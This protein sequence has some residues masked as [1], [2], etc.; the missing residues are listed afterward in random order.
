MCQEKTGGKYEKIS[1][2]IYLTDI[3]YGAIYMGIFDRFRKKEK[4]QKGALL[5]AEATLQ[6]KPEGVINTD[7]I[8][9]AEGILQKYKQGKANLEA[10]II[11]NE[12]W[13]KLRHWEELKKKSKPGEPEPVSAWLFNSIANKHADAMD[14]SPAPVVLPREQSDE[15]AAKALT[16][17]LPVVLDQNEYDQ[18]YSDMWW[19]KLKTGTGVTGVFWDSSKQNGLGDI[20]IRTIDLLNLFWEPG[21]KDIQKSPNLFHVE[22]V[23]N[24]LLKQRYPEC[25]EKLSSPT[26]DIGR[27]IYEDSID[28]SDK[29]AVVDWYYKVNVNGRD[30]VHFCK[31]V[32]GTVL[33]ASENDPEY[34]ERGFYDH[35]QY[36][37]VF[38]T[39]FPEEGTPCGF[40]YIDVGKSPQAYIDKLDQCIQ[41]Y[42]VM[43]ANPRFFVRGD[44]G[45]NE[46]EYADWTKAFIHYS[47]N[48]DPSESVMP[49]QIPPLSDI[50]VSVRQLKVEELKET[51]G[52]RDFS[53]GG[54]AAGVTAASAIAALQEAGNKLSRDMLKSSYRAFKKVVSLSIE[55]MRQFY[56]TPRYFRVISDGGMQYTQFS[57][58]ALM[59]QEQGMDFGQDMGMRMPVFDLDVKVQKS[60]TFSTIAENERAKELYGMGFFRPDLADQALAALDM[61]QFDNIEKVK[62]RISQNGLLFQQVQQ[63]QQQV[64]QMAAIIDSQN[65]TNFSAGAAMAAGGAAAPQEGGSFRDGMTNTLGDSFSGA[66]N[67]TAGNA[68]AGTARRATPK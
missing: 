66:M 64:M 16:E 6:P 13:Y 23:S 1:A 35:G 15:Q 45:I 42:S 53:Q 27:Y 32:N 14:N 58:E 18:V 2:K 56:D 26:I 19:Y 63:L 62:E 21:I 48:Q 51:T 60:A 10:R 12:Q 7:A 40:G 57:N 34:A 41:K 49:L 22:L 65:G 38:D 5:P 43:A 55:L 47:G 39:L 3:F 17:I 24:S 29:S 52:N 33:Y 8:I 54:T 31:F 67:K 50:Y 61:M 36:P 4:E 30:I 9:E 11:S 59:P 20:D 68:K 37:F 46:K 44:G 28:T 25:A